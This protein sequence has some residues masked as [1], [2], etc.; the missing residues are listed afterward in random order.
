MLV[1]VVAVAMLDPI[2]LVAVRVQVSD[3]VLVGVDTEVH[4][5][6]PQPP[7]QSP[8]GTSHGASERRS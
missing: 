7:Q 5:V 1:L 6:P 8:G 4:A 2:V 3:A